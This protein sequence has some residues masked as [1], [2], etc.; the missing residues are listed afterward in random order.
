MDNTVN[1]IEHYCQNVSSIAVVL[2]ENGRGVMDLITHATV[3][4]I[5]KGREGV[6]MCACVNLQKSASVCYF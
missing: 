1:L 6:L 4:V 2:Y 3:F 5:R